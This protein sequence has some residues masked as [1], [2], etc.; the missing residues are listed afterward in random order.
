LQPVSSREREKRIEKNRQE[1]C[2]NVDPALR[3]SY[4]ALV[5]TDQFYEPVEN[6]TNDFSDLAQLVPLEYKYLQARQYITNAYSDEAVADGL[7][8]LLEIAQ[9]PSYL[10]DD[11]L[12]TVLSAGPPLSVADVDRA[13]VVINQTGGD[14]VH[15]AQRQIARADCDRFDWT[16]FRGAAS[17]TMKEVGA[18]CGH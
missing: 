16:G 5:K 12:A 9:K 13:L 1:Q 15:E 14:Y 6:P 3:A 4:D 2:A 10:A 11:A 18:R 8:A 17:A 7:K